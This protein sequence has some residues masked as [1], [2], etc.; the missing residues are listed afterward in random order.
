MLYIVKQLTSFVCPPPSF[1]CGGGG[2]GDGGDGKAKDIQCILRSVI[3]YF[4]SHFYLEITSLLL[5][6]PRRRIEE[7]HDGGSRPPIAL[8]A[9]AMDLSW[10]NR[11]LASP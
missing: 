3:F 9:P 11:H 1:S 5:F 2:G 6:L 7:A 10:A 8:G 4:I